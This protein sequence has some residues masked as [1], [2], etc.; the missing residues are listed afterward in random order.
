VSD[1]A[2]PLIKEEGT[3]FSDEEV[4]S[5]SEEL[6]RLDDE[7]RVQARNENA[8]EIAEHDADRMLVVSGP[9]TGKSTL[10][11]RRL[12]YWLAEHADNRVA[13]A[14]FVRSLVRDL[15]DDIEIDPG[16]S[17]EDKK[18]VSV[19]TMHRHARSIIERNHG[20]QELKLK[21]NCAIP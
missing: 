18:R 16:I 7:A 4:A 3:A 19:M 21:K 17:D 12:I 6:D 1:A 10:F 15:C 5:L 20:T 9:G 8:E 14:R 11:K 2:V 13:V